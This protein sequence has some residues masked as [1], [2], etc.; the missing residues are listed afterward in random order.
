[1]RLLS[2]L[3]FFIVI[4]IGNF[5][6]AKCYDGKTYKGQVENNQA[7]GYGLAKWESKKKYIGDDTRYFRGLLVKSVYLEYPNE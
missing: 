2:I 5:S 4:F 1:M 6:Y 7:H 3:I